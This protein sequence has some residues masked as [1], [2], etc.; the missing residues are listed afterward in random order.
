MSILHSSMPEPVAESDIDMDSIPFELTESD[1]EN[2]LG[3][4]EHFNPHTWEELKNIIGST[5]LSP[6]P[7]QM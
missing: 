3:G 2:L 6:Y 7:P 5:H 4:D 1:R